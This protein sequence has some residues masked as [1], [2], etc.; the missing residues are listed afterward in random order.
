MKYF[1]FLSK[2]RARRGFTLI[3]IL[4]VI[5]IIGILAAMGAAAYG[6][7]LQSGRNAKRINDIKAIGA[8]MEQRYTFNGGSYDAYG[9]AMPAS[10][11]IDAA[12]NWAVPT[13]PGT[14]AYTMRGSTAT[15]YCVCAQLEPFDATLKPAGNNSDIVSCGAYATPNTHYC[16]HQ[17][18]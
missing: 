8:M 9:S 18:Q 16:E 14:T 10:I 4:I 12:T 2:T 3:E 15:A 5:V 11:P 17:R 7:A 6:N 13:A 1:S